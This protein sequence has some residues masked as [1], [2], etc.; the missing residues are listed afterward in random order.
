MKSPV[1]GVSV[2]SLAAA[3]LWCEEQPHGEAFITLDIRLRDAAQREGFAIK[4]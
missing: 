4:P 2:V 1:R 3:L